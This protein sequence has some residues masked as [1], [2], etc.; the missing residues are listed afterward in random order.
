MKQQRSKTGLYIQLEKKDWNG[1]WRGFCSAI[2][3][4]DGVTFNPPE[5]DEDNWWFIPTKWIPTV[6]ILYSKFIDQIIKDAK[7]DKAAGFIPIPRQ[8]T[9]KFARKQLRF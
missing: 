8:S 9:S 5:F 3:K 1:D 4:L 2:K 6:K 7:A